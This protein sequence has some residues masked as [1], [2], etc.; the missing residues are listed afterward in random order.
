VENVTSIRDNVLTGLKN[1][2]ATLALLPQDG[3]GAP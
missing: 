3:H 2:A 1:L